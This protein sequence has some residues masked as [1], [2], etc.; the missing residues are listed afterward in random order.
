ETRQER[1]ESLLA[2][3]SLHRRYGHIQEVIIQNFCPKA[4]SRMSEHENVPLKEHLWTISCA[5]LMFGAQM[6]IQAP[7]NLQSNALHDLV[8][9]GINDWGGISPVT[10]DYV[11]PEKPWPDL[12]H[13]RRR[14]DQ[15][16]KVLVPRLPV[17]PAYVEDRDKWIDPVFHQALLQR[18]DS[19]GLLRECDWVA[20]SRHCIPPDITKP[21]VAPS[22]TSGNTSM[23]INRALDGKRLDES[24][25]ASLFNVRGNEFS[26]VITAADRL[27]LDMNGDRVSYVV[28][29]NIN[30]TNIC[31]FKCGFC[32]FSKAVGNGDLRGKPYDLVTEEIV[33]RA[34]EA[35]ARGATEVCMQG[36]IHPRYTGRHYIEI[37]KAVK[38][39]LPGVHI[40]AFSPLEIFQGANSLAMS[41]ESFLSELKTNGLDTLPGTAAEILDDEIREIICP[42]KLTTQQWLDVVATAHSLGIRSSSTIMFGHV[43][44]PINWA[45]HLLAIRDL[46]CNTGG[47]TEFVP[48]PFVPE[49][50]PIFRKGLARRGPT[51]RETLLMHAVARLVLHP[52]VVNIQTS[53][54][55]MGEMGVE[56][57]LQAGANDLGG[58]LMNESIS[59]AAGADHAQEMSPEEL[60]SIAMRVGRRT[61]QRNTMYGWIDPGWTSPKGLTASSAPIC[62]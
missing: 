10:R 58:T 50:T 18:V 29:R 62:N 11:N 40:H 55:K 26:E 39:A 32:A 13:L 49:K 4:N 8:K 53:W 25:V 5:R 30:Y 23:L 21:T 31:Y 59:H 43:D 57:C 44:K 56:A 33:T 61:Q 20:G 46:Q 7:P 47:I 37:C 54:V 6:T 17:Y 12:E 36:G 19:V 15:M 3:R 42:D 38:A 34:R 51:F 14:C 60:S 22:L 41:V 24:S 1:I 2:L 16:G 9:A 52:H 28:N 35:W 48:L 27:R 45:R